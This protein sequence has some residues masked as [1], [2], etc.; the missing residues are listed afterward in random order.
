M[1]SF[2]S[3]HHERFFVLEC[4]AKIGLDSKKRRLK[5]PFLCHST[6]LFEHI[7]L[8]VFLDI[9]NHAITQ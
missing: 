3:V 6:S 7:R 4:M 9:I 5:R 8:A 1:L 2:K